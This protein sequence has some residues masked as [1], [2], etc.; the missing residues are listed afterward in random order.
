[1]LEK[2]EFFPDDLKAQIPK[3]Y[4]QEKE[5]DPTVWMKFFT[6]WTSWTW[7]ITEGEEQDGDF[8]MFG[9]VVGHAREWGYVSMNELKSVN[10]PMGLKIERDIHF[11]PKKA[12]EV[13]DIHSHYKPKG[14]YCGKCDKETLHEGG[15][16]VPC[17]EGS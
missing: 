3:L 11:S 9:Y 12:S 4:S 10:G 15:Q 8:L 1:M 13:S 14:T 17:I 6:P 7:F 5:K 2:Y 16:C